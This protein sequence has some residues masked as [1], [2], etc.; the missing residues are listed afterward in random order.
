M[1]ES[2]QDE[3]KPSLPKTR[4]DSASKALF[5][6]EGSQLAVRALRRAAEMDPNNAITHQLLATNYKAM[7][8]KEES[9]NELKAAAELSQR[10]DARP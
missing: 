5:D 4:K 9:D 1:S 7:G 2:L 6:S 10:Q 8:M 3:R